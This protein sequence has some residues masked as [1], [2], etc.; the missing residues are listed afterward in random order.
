MRFV[1]GGSDDDDDEVEEYEE[2]EV[3]VG[4]AGVDN[5]CVQYV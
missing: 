3:V 5:G 1:K 4:N 2:E